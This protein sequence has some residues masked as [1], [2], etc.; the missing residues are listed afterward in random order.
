MPDFIVKTIND[1]NIVIEADSFAFFNVGRPPIY[2]F[3][4]K[5]EDGTY[6]IVASVPLSPEILGVVE[7]SAVQSDHYSYFDWNEEDEK[8]NA[9]NYDF[10]EDEDFVDAVLALIDSWHKGPDDEP[11]TAEVIQ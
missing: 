10:L 5:R 11:E 4:K 9:E 1:R 3:W 2:E 6:K 8:E 7:E